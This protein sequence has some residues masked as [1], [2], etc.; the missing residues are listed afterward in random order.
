MMADKKEKLMAAVRAA[1]E[2]FLVALANKGLY[3]RAARECP[4]AGIAL[5][6]T[7]D[8]VRA[9]FADGTEVVLEQSIAD[10]SCSCPSRSV[11]KH[12]L[13]AIMAIQADDRELSPSD[14]GYGYLRDA[15]P[16]Q[17]AK[18]S[19]KRI[20]QEAVTVALFSE[21]AI[22]R[23]ESTLAIELKDSGQTVRFL[24]FAA[25]EDAVCTCKAEKF[26]AHRV[27]AVLQY[28]IAQNGA[29]PEAFLLEETAAEEPEALSLSFATDFLTRLFGAGL[30]RMPDSTRERISQLAT[31][32]HS[33]KLA[34]AERLC[35]RI[36]GKLELFEAK[37]TSF[38]KDGLIGDL[39]AL[40]E[41]L[42]RLEAEGVSRQTAGVFKDKYMPVPS[43]DILGLGVFGWHSP[44]GFTGVTALFYEPAKATDGAGRM[45][46]YTSALPDAAAPDPVRMAH[47]AAPWS[48]GA[49]FIMASHSRLHLRNA[50]ISA[51]GRLSSTESCL[52]EVIGG[53]SIGA[54]ELASIRYD[55]FAKL[56]EDFRAYAS[57]FSGSPRM[58]AL[59]APASADASEYDKINQVWR[60]TLKDQAGRALQ[61]SVRYEKATKLLIQ[62]LM[63][64]CEK[65]GTAET[66]GVFLAQL[67]LS[68]GAL[69]AFPVTHF[70]TEVIDL[71]LFVPPK[72][73]EDEEFRFDWGD[74][75]V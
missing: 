9:T 16:E 6:E 66:P 69:S 22:I 49:Q 40:F 41:M 73:K 72:K 34:D 8:G 3:N 5:S 12:L 42:E 2:Q 30:A 44:G 53:V 67:S 38:D 26:C 24:P 28:L 68:N 59:I 1:D 19:G 55:D 23:E 14:D 47:G 64:L 63:K 36:A 13:M 32:C 48:A 58:P 39:C 25:F 21:P 43:L 10:Y 65:I 35:G 29:L 70:G 74:V 71:S 56:S 52:A 20:F 46:E 27:Q 51:E 7:E 61:L 57:E 37:S 17:L 18:L 4:D 60:M 45:L 54:P 33:R 50:K 75:P 31:I 62:N 15:A 11:C